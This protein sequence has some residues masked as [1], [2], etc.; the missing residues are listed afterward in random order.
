M[1]K[2]N[3]VYLQ[4]DRN[5]QGKMK[6]TCFFPPCLQQP[7]SYRKDWNKG[8][9]QVGLSETVQQPFPARKETG[10][11]A[12]S[13]VPISAGWPHCLCA[14]HAAPV[15]S[16]E[17]HACLSLEFRT[18]PPP[19]QG[20]SPFS[21]RIGSQ[22]QIKTSIL[23]RGGCVPGNLLKKAVKCLARCNQ[24]ENTTFQSKPIPLYVMYRKA[25]L[26]S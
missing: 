17:G 14:H 6:Q 7:Y 10:P 20:S 16:T 18:S 21:L 23:I 26:D 8:R 1:V 15:L 25:D 5:R 22:L 9:R 19:C 2:E 24:L 4:P 12:A 11:Q 13:T 3:G